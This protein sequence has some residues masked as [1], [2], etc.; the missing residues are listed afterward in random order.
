MYVLIKIDLLIHLCCV[1]AHLSLLPSD[2]RRD[3]LKYY[4]R[5]SGYNGATV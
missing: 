3:H 1:L 4:Y 5:L 2:F